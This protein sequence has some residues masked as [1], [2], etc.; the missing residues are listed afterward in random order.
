MLDVW[1]ATILL[2]LYERLS[3]SGKMPDYIESHESGC[4][5]DDLPL[6]EE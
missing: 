6:K 3:E 1:S 4:F 2:L 5:I